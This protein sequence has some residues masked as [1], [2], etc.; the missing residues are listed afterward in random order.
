MSSAWGG[1]DARKRTI[2][3]YQRRA[4]EKKHKVNPPGLPSL[5]G[6]STG[7]GTSEDVNM[8][9]E[10]PNVIPHDPPADP[11]SGGDVSMA[12]G[13]SAP[14]GRTDG[15]ETG[16]DPFYA[17][18]LRPFM[19]TQ[20][21]IHPM[22]RTGNWTLA[23]GNTSTSVKTMTI[24]INSIWDVLTSLTYADD[25]AAAAGVG[26]GASETPIM[27]EFWQGIYRYW[28]CVK[29]HYKVRF[30]TQDNADQEADI[31]CYHHGQQMPPITLGG[32]G[33][34]TMYSK[35]RRL[36]RHAHYKTLG[37]YNSTATEKP[38]FKGREVVFEGWYE[39]GNRT[40]VNDVAED[41]YKETWHKVTEVPSLQEYVTFIGQRSERSGTGSAFDIKFD[42]ELVFYVQW[43][44]L[45]AKFQ[46]M[47]PTADVTFT[48]FASEF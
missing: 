48:D 7:A 13:S 3:E 25:P 17:P 38:L 23:T 14:G 8:A 30:W 21:T 6:T 16:V 27:R 44:D 18:R 33:G 39:P 11:P 31:W 47:D 37:T 9:G 12:L 24:R 22:Y 19:D 40:V 42:I 32:S 35:Y 45:K 20:N 36:H 34:A 5:R 2:A 43:K 46:Y 10:G 26:D 28:T 29:T 41:E 15:S 4:N 1:A